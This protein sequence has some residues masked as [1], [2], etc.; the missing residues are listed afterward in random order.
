MT[1]AL[2]WIPGDQS[3]ANL[4]RA[5]RSCP[6]FATAGAEFN[7]LRRFRRLNCLK[8]SEAAPGSPYAGR[9]HSCSPPRRQLLDEAH[10]F[11]QICRDL[12]RFETDLLPP[13]YSSSPSCRLQNFPDRLGPWR[14][15]PLRKSPRGQ[16]AP[17]YRRLRRKNFETLQRPP[18]CACQRPIP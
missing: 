15:P 18:M 6:N 10:R 16:A 9:K 7:P 4:A 3:P 13:L 2:A 11:Q 5:F 14:R 8:Q 1:A 17:W 12:K